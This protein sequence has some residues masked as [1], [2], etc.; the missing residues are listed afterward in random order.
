M[1]GTLAMNCKRENIIFDINRFS[2]KTRGGSKYGWYYDVQ[3]Y[4][5]SDIR[6]SPKSGFSKYYVTKVFIWW[7]LWT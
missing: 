5:E 3:V 1:R 7:T 4:N 6:T 2:R